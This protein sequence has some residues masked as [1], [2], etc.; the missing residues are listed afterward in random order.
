MALFFASFFIGLYL[1]YSGSKAYTLCAQ[2]GFFSSTGFTLIV[3]GEVMASENARY[4]TKG[5]WIFS[6]LAF[7]ILAGMAYYFADRKTIQPLKTKA[8]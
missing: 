3:I 7:Q 4:A 5:V 6:F 8:P 1:L 2:V